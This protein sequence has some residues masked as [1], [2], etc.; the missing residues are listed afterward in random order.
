LQRALAQCHGGRAAQPRHRL[1]HGWV[2]MARGRVDLARRAL[3]AA[4]PATSGSLEPRDELL[5]A[6]LAVAL[7]RRAHD[8]GALAAAWGR[9]RDAL[10]RHPV[11]LTTL[12]QL[13]ELAV[14][15]A[16][17]GEEGWL[18]AHLAEADDLL[19]RLGRPALWSVPLHW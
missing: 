19:D 18:V 16:Q 2:L 11:D 7:A 14:A 12:F 5:A 8:P 9:A 10:V 1:L 15:T 3:T 17:L 13:G 6:A 4:G